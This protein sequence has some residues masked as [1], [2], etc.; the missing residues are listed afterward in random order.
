[1]KHI[2]LYEDHEYKTLING[3][4]VAKGSIQ[5]EGV[6]IK[7]HPDYTDAYAVKAEFTDGKELTS[8][9]LDKLN[10]E[11]RDLIRD[12]AEESAQ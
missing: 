10:D 12:I 5:L 3:K 1:M 8:N 2:K 4:E 11:Y 7:D 6:D 9:E